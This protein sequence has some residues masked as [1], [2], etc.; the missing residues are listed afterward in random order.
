M[1]IKLDEK[2]K[3]KG[4]KF[5]VFPQPGFLKS[6]KEPEEVVV[7]LSPKEIKS[8]PSD[9]RF[10]VV[11][12]KNKL[13]YKYPYIP[14]YNGPRYPEAT[15][16]P[17]F[18]HFI[19]LKVNSR[20]FFSAHMYACVR[21]TLDIWEDYF[22]SKIEWHFSLSYDR[23]ELIPLIF[24]PNAQA[25]WGF[26][27]FGYGRDVFGDIDIS[28]PYSANF[29]VIAHEL[30]HSIVFSRVG[31]PQNNQNN[32]EYF[33]F[34]EAISDLVAVISSLHFNKVLDYLLEQTK[35]D[36]FTQHAVGRIGELSE[37][38]QIRKAFNDE[39][40]STVTYSKPHDLSKPLTGAIFDIMVEIFQNNLVDNGLI[41]KQ[42]ADLSNHKPGVYVDAD[43]VSEEFEKA[44]KGNEA[45]FKEALL[46]AR[47]YLGTLLA[48]LMD[49]LSPNGLSFLGVMKELI[50]ADA[51]IEGV[52]NEKLIRDSFAFREI[53][54]SE[55]TFEMCHWT[56]E[57]SLN[58]R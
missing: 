47:D 27:E 50:L 56:L 15:A 43:L 21:R 8:G 3:D 19:H 58:D 44:Y 24:W 20:E 41:T 2:I 38:R 6:F 28:K 12:A 37:N 34:H 40:M 17:E 55:A 36:L 23:M 46:E 25:G 31:F 35:G 11:D 54:V 13:P 14:P 5:L 39:K 4:T 57:E 32:E 30:G 18:G 42:L 51:S 22:E 7:S 53:G 1:S 48:K 33:G 9:D 29:D 26:L 10:Y 49:S 16:D 52:S 45:A